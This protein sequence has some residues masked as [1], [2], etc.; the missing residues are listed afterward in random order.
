MME[1]IC[2]LSWDCFCYVPSPL[3]QMC[4]SYHFLFLRSQVSSSWYTGHYLCRSEDQCV[5]AGWLLIREAAETGIVPLSW[6]RWHCSTTALPLK[7]SSWLHASSQYYL[8]LSME[9]L[10]CCTG[11]MLCFCSVA[12]DSNTT[13][14]SVA[15]KP[16]VLQ[17]HQ[18]CLHFYT[19][20]IMYFYP[21]TWI[22]DH[23]LDC[24][25]QLRMRFMYLAVPLGYSNIADEACNWPKHVLCSGWFYIPVTSRLNF[26]QGDLVRSWSKNVSS[27]SLSYSF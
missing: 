11:T 20:M 17:Y 4:F 21:T 19:P 26:I 24:I 18:P 13:V 8:W 25:L 2:D 22:S 5:A 27:L 6:C 3:F 15:F 1:I 7:V 10:S 14:C 9:Q 23:S 12:W 16:H